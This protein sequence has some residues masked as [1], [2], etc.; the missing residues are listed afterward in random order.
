MKESGILNWY[1]ASIIQLAPF[2][3]IIT[4]RAHFV[5]K[6]NTAAFI[7]GKVLCD[8]VLHESAAT[9]Y[10]S[11]VFH[12]STLKITAPLK[13]IRGVTGEPTNKY[14][15]H[16]NYSRRAKT[17]LPRVPV[18]ACF[19]RDGASRTLPRSVIVYRKSQGTFDS[20]VFLTKTSLNP[21]IPCHLFNL[22][23]LRTGCKEKE[24][25]KKR[26]QEKTNRKKWKRNPI[27]MS[28]WHPTLAWK[29][30]PTAEAIF[31]TRIPE[32]RK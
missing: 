1:F 10:A 30:A 12:E 23:F 32:K 28:S 18:A 20:R 29:L 14:P 24:K 22:G 3:S 5:S 2:N 27:T 19:P 15:S 11:A 16:L 17:E 9:N 13:N 26:T 7:A 25:K 31:T 8:G 6:R 4:G 21:G